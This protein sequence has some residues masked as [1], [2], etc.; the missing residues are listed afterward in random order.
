[1]H[2]IRIDEKLR[3]P[4]CGHSWVSIFRWPALIRGHS[5]M[6]CAKIRRWS[7][8]AANDRSGSKQYTREILK[9][10]S[11]QFSVDNPNGYGALSANRM[12]ATCSYESTQ[13]AH[14]LR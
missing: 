8:G 11:L 7:F 5:P 13:Y 2:S 14:R 12:Y 9:T 6:G 10:A 1:M 4:S 3:A